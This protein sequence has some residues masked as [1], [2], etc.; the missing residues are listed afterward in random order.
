MQ[1][2]TSMRIIYMDCSH[3]RTGTAKTVKPGLN[4][5]PPF[6]QKCKKKNKATLSLKLTFTAIAEKWSKPVAQQQNNREN[7]NR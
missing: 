4:I 1:I 5:T 7:D 3:L 6:L 2:H